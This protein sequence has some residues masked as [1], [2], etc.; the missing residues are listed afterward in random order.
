MTAT[1]GLKLETGVGREHEVG[2]LFSKVRRTWLFFGETRRTEVHR[3]IIERGGGEKDEE[4]KKD[5][6]EQERQ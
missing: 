6:A 1:W 3:S 2:Q 5:K 4:G